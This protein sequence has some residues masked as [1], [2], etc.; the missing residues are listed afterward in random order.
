M[1][2]MGWPSVSMPAQ[3]KSLGMKLEK[4]DGKY[5]GTPL[6][7][8]EKTAAKEQDKAKAQVKK[9]STTPETMPGSSAGQVKPPKAADI[10][11]GPAAGSPPADYSQFLGA[12]AEAAQTKD[13]H[14]IAGLFKFNPE[15]A[16]T[17]SS[18][19]T[20]AGK[21][22]IE[23]IVPGVFDAYQAKTAPKATEAELK[24]AVKSTTLPINTTAPAGVLVI[25]D[26]NDKYA[27]KD[28]LTPEQLNQKVQDYKDLQA[29]LPKLTAEY[30]AQS[31]AEKAASEKKA[32]D[33]AKKK[34]AEK[35]A[36]QKAEL[37]EQFAADPTLK[38]HYE[39]AEALFGGKDAG[40][41][42]AAAAANKV[43]AAGLSKYMSPADAIPII[44]YS[45]SHYSQVNSQLRAGKMTEAQDKF[46]QSLNAGLDKLPSHNGTTYRKAS[47]TPDQVAL[48]E[49]GYVIEER[50]FMSTSKTQ[51]TWSGSHNFTIHGKNGKDIQKLSSHPSEAEVLFKSGSRFKV[52][53]RQGTN[54]V[55]QEV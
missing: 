24:K 18:N 19:A 51:G 35:V 39:A 15:W 54:I 48:Y 36:K 37:E 2:T 30:E 45:G 3:A 1:Q 44:A 40:A 20:P 29:V 55:L 10:P 33:E 8:A 42:Y 14:A 47:L 16:K 27:G 4:K 6:T 53:S 7:D 17:F 50:G 26:F 21:A 12:V 23:K 32:L 11:A 43:K 5:F 34:I 49:P 28:N 22:A 52:L 9:G 13:V 31:K 46:R 38:L 41:S 25:K